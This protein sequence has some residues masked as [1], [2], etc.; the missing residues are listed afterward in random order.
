MQRLTIVMLGEP[1]LAIDGEPVACS[2]KKAL[3]LLYFLARAGGRPTRRE[4]ARLLWGGDQ[5]AARSSLRTALQRLPAAVAT[6]LAVDRERIGLH[7][8]AP[9]SIEI[10]T[11][12]F[13]ALA[14]S[15]ELSSL[16][17]AADLYGGDFLKDLELDASPDFDDWLKRERA[18]FRQVAQSV[19]DRLIAR[20][21][22]LAQRDTGLASS[23]REA[24]MAA[25]RRWAALEPAA[26]RAHRWLMRLLFEAGQRE[27]ALAQYE[28]CQR[29]LAVAMG[30]GPDAETRSLADAILAGST[31]Q[32]QHRPVVA[33]ALL[34]EQALH[35]VDV[36]ATTF[37]GRIDELAHLEQLTSDPACRLLT[38]HALGGSGKSRLAYV[39][40]A[41]WAARFA[42]GATWIALD[43]VFKAEHLPNAMARA[44]GI[45]LPAQAEPAASLCAALQPQERL[46]VLDNFEQLIEAGGTELVLRILRA[47]PA[48]SF[49]V[50][51]RETLGV[52]EEWVYEVPGLPFPADAAVQTPAASYP[53]VELFMQRARQA[54]LGFSPQA[55]WP[56]VVRICRLV[57]GLPLAIELAAAWVRTVP[58]G[59]LANAI[60]T[61]MS[62]MATKHRNRPARQRSLDAV[63]RTSW[64]LLTREQQLSLA[65]LALCRGG[66]TQE[67]AQA[68]A[69]ATLRLLSTLVDK[70]LVLRRP[71]GRFGLHELVRQFLQARLSARADAQRQAQRRYLV[72]YAGQLGRLRSQLDGPAELEAEAV[73][74][75]ELPNL[76][77]AAELLQTQG[78]ELSDASA[79]PLLRVLLSRGMVR[80]AVDAAT[81]FLAPGLALSPSVRTL[82]LAN[83]GR[84]HAMLHDLASARDDFDAAIELARRN[85]LGYPLA[86]S[87]LY[88]QSIAHINDDLADAIAGIDTLKVLVDAVGDPA[89]AL[90]A[91]YNAGVL[92]DSNGQAAESERCF[93]EAHDIALEI[94]SP[95]MIATVQS[96]LAPALVKQ[97]RVEEGEA[98]L[99]ESLSLFE[100]IGSKHHLAR[101]LNSLATVSLWRFG[102]EQADL[103]ARDA[104][105]SLDLYEQVGYASG[106]SAALDTLGQAE[107]MR[108]RFAEARAH[109]E[110]AIDAGTPILSCEAKFHLAFVAMSEG[111]VSEAREIAGSL[112]AVAR[113]SALAPI[114][115]WAVLLCAALALD[116]GGDEAQGQ[117]WLRA[118]LADSDLE[119]DMKRQ[120]EQLLALHPA[121]NLFGIDMAT[122]PALDELSAFLR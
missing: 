64:Q 78:R 84:A 57:E 46:L 12:R 36:P 8:N 32:G 38:L 111:G 114:A 4:L 60:A 47:A 5:E 61:E 45:E 86:Y 50:T 93:R 30:R 97:G 56:H 119:F 83:R 73:L 81:R 94:G 100:K 48:V 58:C 85:E 9:S 35:A 43:A 22:E 99:R 15:E 72:H 42:L 51:S 105:R 113:E 37:V 109:F 39:L 17:A 55:E 91:R 75:V 40:A 66:F 108:G 44:L 14:K 19:F 10:D 34:P 41:Q 7:G 88:A 96:S 18:G 23:G 92:F 106:R 112:V 67:A 122:L 25:A 62:A 71:D 52:Q 27:A 13:E 74:S 117:R 90:R 3:G 87:L 69:G 53:A 28:A 102:A 54:Y 16:S 121:V 103:A 79:E 20:H 1:R 95:T 65:P 89:L 70:S 24:A 107:A 104:A 2:S 110:Q 116:S 59:D 21:R 29:E 33:R 82:V 31:G 120:A 68:V 118:L 6:W 80:D 26:E 11:Q 98:L 76:L 77:A 115:R 49:L 63:V 101:A